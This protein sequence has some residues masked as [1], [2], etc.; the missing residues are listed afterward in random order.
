MNAV[1]RTRLC[2]APYQHLLFEYN[3]YGYIV[4]FGDTFGSNVLP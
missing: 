2:Q 4:S 3:T 1:G